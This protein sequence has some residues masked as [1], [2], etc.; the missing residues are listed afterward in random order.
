MQV[1]NKKIK[2][3]L[4]SLVISIIVLCILMAINSSDFTIID[5]KFIIGSIIIASIIASL[6]LLIKYKSFS[7]KI[8]NLYYQLTDFC[9]LLIS[10]IAVLQFVFIFLFFPALV[11]GPSMMPTLT[12][13]DF[14]IVKTTNRIERFNM[15]VVEVEEEFND[16]NNNVKDEDL[17]IKRII[18]VPGD[19]FYY[20]NGILHLN[21]TTVEEEYLKDENGNYHNSPFIYNSYT[22]DFKIDDFKNIYNLE[23]KNGKYY[24][25]EDF[26]FVMG[27]NREHSYDS[28]RSLGLFHKSQIK[29]VPVYRLN[30][31][32][33]WEKLK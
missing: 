5:D 31:I 10:A 3:K 20:E 27:D 26:Y 11:D 29:G 24:I 21:G 13:K 28:S 23:Y 2:Y 12:D 15:V 1:S 16:M 14:L 7:E 9:F 6:S 30:S 4:I 18:G 8:R 25:P 33:D 22:R 19:T 17:L 32:F